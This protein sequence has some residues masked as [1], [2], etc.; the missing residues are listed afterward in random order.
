[1]SGRRYIGSGDIAAI[2]ALYRPELAHVARWKS[3]GDVWL[4]LVHDIDIPSKRGMHRGLREENPLRKV[5]RDTIGPCSDL[6]GLIQH[7]RFEW[8][9]GSPDG[10]ADGLVVELKTHSV[11]QRQ[12][13]G[14]E[15]W[16]DKVP[17]KYATQVQW[18]MGLAQRPACHILVGFGRD[19]VDENGEDFF[20]WSETV[21]YAL[22]FDPAMYSAMESM[23]V[24][25]YTE[26]V[27]ARVSPSAA[28]VHNRR[29]WKKILESGNV[30][31]ASAVTDS[32][33]SLQTP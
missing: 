27:L 12:Q 6:P 2:V 31:S 14:S 21:P 20:A 16:S 26:H 13:W 11:F 24:R 3:A 18:L 5:Y 29:T 30:D 8:A 23:A 32:N 25:F 4:R 10:L 17:D 1:M 9:G 15:P 19:S 33:T 7:P 28:P 22:R